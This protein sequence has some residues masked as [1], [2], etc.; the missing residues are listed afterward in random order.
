MVQ[1]MLRFPFTLVSPPWRPIGIERARVGGDIAALRATLEALRAYPVLVF[2]EGARRRGE[3]ADG[4][5]GV[6]W[7]ALRSGVPVLPAALLGAGAALPRGAHWPRRVP[8]TLRVG[9][10]VDLD[11]AAAGTRSGE[12]A[13][14]AAAAIMAAIAAV[15]AVPS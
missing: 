1:G 8:L 5:S 2:P 10:A 9:P 14:L 15:E 3:V 4:H 12:R 11:A 13:E 7:L 6:G